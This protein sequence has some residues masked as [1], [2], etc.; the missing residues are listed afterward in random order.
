MKKKL[1]AIFSILFILIIFF[2][3]FYKG[4]LVIETNVINP[5]V[6]IDK[7]II[8]SQQINLN[9]GKH[10]IIIRKTGY[11][12]LEQDI[13]IKAFK[14]NDLNISLPPEPEVFVKESV[15]SPELSKD[16]K[17]LYYF[18]TTNNYLSK[19]S[20]ENKNKE[21]LSEKIYQTVKN[22]YWS[23]D[24]DKAIVFTIERNNNKSYLYD[25][26]SKS[27]ITLPNNI[28]EPVSWSPNNNQIAYRSA[29]PVSEYLSISSP[30]GS[31][32]E[33]IREIK[34]ITKLIWQKK[35]KII[36][37]TIN[38][39]DEIYF[40]IYELNLSTKEVTKIGNDKTFDFKGYETNTGVELLIQSLEDS[41]TKTDINF[42]K[43]SN[44]TRAEIYN[45][46]IESTLL[47]ADKKLIYY[48]DSLNSPS[49]ESYLTIKNLENLK[50]IKYKLSSLSKI[51][52][53]MLSFTDKEILFLQNNNI[54]ILGVPNIPWN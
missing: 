54:Y 4:K 17:A 51:N 15:I 30:D 53:I 36:F 14:N 49:G 10:R 22:I 20:I 35:E 33:D 39:D 31:S 34:I 52:Q 48:L 19:I 8:N 3:Y 23:P 1:I 24:K 16:R 9:P 42:Y 28:Q 47:S 13:N 26:K 6:E 40:P 32:K 29:T 38:G 25:L 43:N 18:D 7:K 41:Y 21:V 46:P 50:E 45:I 37:T 44:L 12:T 2:I 11:K 27:K 5:T